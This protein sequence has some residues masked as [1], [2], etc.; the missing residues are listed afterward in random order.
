MQLLTPAQ[1]AYLRNLFQN[2][3]VDAERVEPGFSG[4]SLVLAHTPVAG[5]R[6]DVFANGVLLRETAHYSLSGATLT[7]TGALDEDDVVVKYT[8]EAS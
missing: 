1:I 3:D 8:W 2:N 4:S 6:I 5:R 7:F